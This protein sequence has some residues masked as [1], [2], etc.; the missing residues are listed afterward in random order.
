MG[1]TVDEALVNA[2]DALR[3]YAIEAERNG[4]EI[5]RPSPFQAIETPVGNQLVSIPLTRPS[6]IDLGAW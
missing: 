6:D 4:D 2:G 5:A 1:D 3:D